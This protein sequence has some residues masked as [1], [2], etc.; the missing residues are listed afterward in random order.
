[1]K[2]TL[3]IEYIRTNNLGRSYNQQ[4][5]K[6]YSERQLTPEQ[7]EKLYDAGFLGFGQETKTTYDGLNANNEHEY[8]AATNCDSGD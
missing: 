8:T 6:V 3:R 5:Y 7:F 4:V 1:M 2:T